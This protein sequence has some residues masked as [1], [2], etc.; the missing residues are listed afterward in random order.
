MAMRNGSEQ[1][2]LSMGMGLTV[3]LGKSGESHK[4]FLCYYNHHFLLPNYSM[5]EYRRGTI[6]TVRSR[7]LFG[8]ALRVLPVC[9]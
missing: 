3:P 5:L 4:T 8:V 2:G 9:L 6:L 1:V 7:E